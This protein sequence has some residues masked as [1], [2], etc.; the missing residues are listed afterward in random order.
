MKSLSSTQHEIW[1]DQ[2]LHPKLP[3]YNIGGYL[4]IEGAVEPI[5]FEK[6]LNQVI[7]ENDALRIILHEG[8]NLPTQTFA[9]ISALNWIFMIFPL[10]QMPMNRLL[11]G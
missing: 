7:E 1:F 3:Q 10:R 5:V 6:A 4:Q 9:K 8:E 2:I 11:L